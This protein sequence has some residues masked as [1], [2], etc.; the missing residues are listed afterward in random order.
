MFDYKFKKYTMK[1]DIDLQQDVID[2][3]DWEPSIESSRIGVS[4]KNGIITLSGNVPTYYEKIAAEKAAKRVDGVRAVVE[5]IEVELAS[6][7]TD[8]DIA[9]AAVRNLKWN[10]T[11]PEENITIKIEEG[12][13]TLEGEVRWN[14]QKEAAKNEVTSLAGVRGVTNR[15]S[16]EPSLKFESPKEKIAKALERD[17][18]IDAHRID[19]RIEGSKAVLEGT[20][21]TWIERRR[22]ERIAWSTPGIFDVDNRIE[23]NVPQVY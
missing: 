17:A 8:E 11:I 9:Q 23:V 1:T 12:W 19:V 15:I 16:V 3:L 2:E 4:V 14:Y 20:V 13:V 6:R 22:A 21:A 10:T 18:I 5:K 7:I